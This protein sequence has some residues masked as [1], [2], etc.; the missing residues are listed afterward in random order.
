MK[1]ILITIV[2][3]L[4]LLVSFGQKITRIEYPEQSDYKNNSIKILNDNIFVVKSFSTKDD[5]NNKNS[6]KIDYYDRNMKLLSTSVIKKNKSWFRDHCVDEQGVDYS[7]YSNSG[8]YTAIIADNPDSLKS[9]IYEF[10]LRLEYHIINIKSYRNKIVFTCIEK[11]IQTFYIIDLDKKNYLRITDPIFQEN[12]AHINIKQILPKYDEVSFFYQDDRTLDVL[13]VLTYDYEGKAKSSF[14]ISS[15]KGEIITKLNVQREGPREIIS[16]TYILEKY[17][18]GAN[19]VF[20]G[21]IKNNKLNFLNLISFMNI[22]SYLKCSTDKEIEKLNNKKEKAEEKDKELVLITQ[23]T[24]APV[25]FSKEE[26]IMFFETGVVGYMDKRFD[27]FRPVKAT[28][29]AFN[30]LGEKKWDHSLKIQRE[31]VGLVKTKDYYLVPIGVKVFNPLSV[32]KIYD[33]KFSLS[34]L[35]HNY[36]KYNILNVSDGTIVTDSCFSRVTLEDDTTFKPFHYPI[37][38]TLLKWYN[39]SYLIYAKE[40]VNKNNIFFIEKVE[41][42]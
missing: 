28:A 13:D 9:E 18:D 12:R 22:P 7:I 39:N 17:I 24:V 31:E 41:L 25:L 6:I 8:S 5:E 19:G 40:K 29:L 32:A 35:K 42:Q 36:I 27:Y 21:E 4:V 33:D 23:A 1:K 16:G 11:N 2:L 26:R 20:F 10:D 15:P 3:I 37:E 38:T 30:E 14:R 34:Y